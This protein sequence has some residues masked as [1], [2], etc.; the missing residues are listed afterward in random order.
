MMARWQILR[1]SLGAALSLAI[2]APVAAQAAPT[3]WQP[4]PGIEACF[5][6]AAE[7]H[8]FDTADACAAL[9]SSARDNDTRAA[10]LFEEMRLA[11]DVRDR[12][13]TVDTLKA[14]DYEAL[15]PNLG[16]EWADLT[17]GACFELDDMACATFAYN[18]L[19]N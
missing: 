17:A 6:P 9:A 15:A 10:L 7:T 3:D 4:G 18:K 1:G 5:A 19:D 8:R 16:I 2:S 14:F 12:E 13:E 11:Y